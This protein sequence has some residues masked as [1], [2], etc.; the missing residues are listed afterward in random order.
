MNDESEMRA[1]R[2]RVSKTGRAV[3]LTV[4][5]L[6]ALG[7]VVVL[8][9]YIQ[10]LLQSRHDQNLG[11]ANEAAARAQA[12]ADAQ[13]FYRNLIPAAEAAPLTKAEIQK[14]SRQQRGINASAP[15]ETTG[16]DV[17]AFRVYEV[18][19]IPGGFGGGEGTVTQC[20]SATLPLPH[21][22]T[23]TVLQATQCPSPASF[24]TAT[25]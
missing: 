17:V 23:P 7:L 13:T 4:G 6:A 9:I 2:V 1:S 22:S 21:A 8:L 14:L 15:V 16:A 25:G 10:M 11:Q 20:Y 5:V 19:I 18:Y 24:G 3:A 12:T